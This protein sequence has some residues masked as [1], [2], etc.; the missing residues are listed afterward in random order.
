MVDYPT[1]PT[2]AGLSYPLREP[3]YKPK[4]RTEFASGAVQSRDRFTRARK[5]FALKWEKMPFADCQKLEA[6]FSKTGADPF[7]WIH[8][9]TAKKYTCIFS[10]DEFDASLV[11]LDY[12]DV[13]VNIE[14][15]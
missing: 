13:T 14:E 5:R 2:I 11:E 6:F 10:D 1:F 3:L 4:S 12:Y 8:P 15:V 7:Y 9:L